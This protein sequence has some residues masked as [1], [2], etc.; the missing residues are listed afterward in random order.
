M[1]Y[2]SKDGYLSN[3]WK[4]RAVRLL[5]FPASVL[6][7]YGILFI[8]MPDKASTALASSGKVIVNLLM[9]LCL[10]FI[11]MLVLNLF[12]KPA[13]ITKF[14]GTGAGIKG[15]LL[16]A[17]AGI[18][19]MGPIYAWYP[20]LKTIR[21]K[22]GDNSLIAIFLCNRA[23]KPFLL[24]I[25]I[26]YFGWIYVPILTVFTIFGSIGVGYCI[27]VSVKENRH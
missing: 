25:M 6:F 17:T 14:L 26:S 27:S 5:V 3:I 24:P 21:E 23:V 19:S 2:L 16:S 9:P 8:V 15:I 20:M 10:V 13:Y 11:L 22:G 4:N 1:I 18:I 7:I 12:L